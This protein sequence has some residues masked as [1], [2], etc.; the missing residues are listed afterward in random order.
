MKIIRQYLL[1]TSNF[2]K[3]TFRYLRDVIVIHLAIV[4][5]IIPVLLRYFRFLI[6]S[7]S[8]RFISIQTIREFWSSDPS[9]LLG[10]VLCCILLLVVVY[11]ECVFLL[12]SMYFIKKKVVI[13]IHTL[14]WATV[15]EM[16]KIRPGCFLFFFFYFFLILPFGGLAVHLD[17]LSVIKLPPFIMD[18][19]FSNRRVLLYSWAIFYLFCTYIGIRCI[20]VIPKMV[21]ENRHL[22]SAVYE[23]WKITKQSFFRLILQFFVITLTI[24][25]SYSL[26]VFLLIRSQQLVEFL[27]PSGAFAFAFVVMTLL[28]IASILNLVLSTAM[29]NYII[30]DYLEEEGKLPDV[31]SWFPQK[32]KAIFSSVFSFILILLVSIMSGSFLGYY[33]AEYLKN[34]SLSMPFLYSHRG[35]EGSYGIQNTIPGLRNVA[36]YHPEFVE[37]DV[38]ETKDHYFVLMHDKNLK[39]LSEQEVSIGGLTLK[40]VKRLTVEEGEQEAEIPT[41]D[42]YLKVA[43]ELKQKVMIELKIYQKFSPA[44]VERFLKRYNKEILQNKHRIQSLNY[45]AVEEMKRID[46]RIYVSYILP[47]NLLGPPETNAD[48]YTMEFSTLNSG[49]IAEAHKLDKQVISWTVNSKKNF[50]RMRSLGV[51]GVITDSVRDLQKYLGESPKRLSYSEKLFIYSLGLDLQ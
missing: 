17:V 22:K 51:D 24:L 26:I 10:L 14:L 38:Q 36:K 25:G 4:L 2:F 42:E 6:S 33:D 15:L 21:L 7:S 45:Q 49:F 31:P 41:L 3:D 50:L 40:E 37:I 18:F 35:V 5:F 27:F 48:A 9:V 30:F 34:D 39:E 43:S 44:I 11:F 32:K 16:Q 28:Q 12:L 13:R 46:S 1:S 19:F 8:L 29:A 47:F 20:F 23:S